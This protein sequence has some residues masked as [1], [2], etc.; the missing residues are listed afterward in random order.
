[1]PEVDVISLAAL[2]SRVWAVP[3]SS[4]LFQLPRPSSSQ[5]W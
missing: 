2:V 5:S 1:M 3:S 4:K